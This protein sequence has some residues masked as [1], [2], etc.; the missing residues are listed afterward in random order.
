MSE[1][2]SADLQKQLQDSQPA[3]RTEYELEGLATF[4]FNYGFQEAYI[5]G[6]RS[7]FLTQSDYKA[8][9]GVETI[10]DFRTVLQDTDYIVAMQG[11]Q[12]P[13]PQTIYAK[14]YEKWVKEF[15]FLKMQGTGKVA[16][17]L[18]LLSHEYLISNVVAL[19][20]ATVKGSSP[21]DVLAHCHPLGNS[22][23]LQS[24]FT[25][26]KEDSLLDLYRIVL[27]DMPIGKYF[28]KYFDAE[29]RSGDPQRA[30][31]GT[32]KEV[33][34]VVISDQLRKLWL[35]ELWDYSQSLGGA[36]WEMMKPM[37]EFEADRRA[38][39]IV[40]NSI[41]IKSSYS[42]PQHRAARQDLFCSFGKLYPTC[43]ARDIGNFINVDSIAA[44]QSAVDYVPEYANALRQA[45]EGTTTLSDALKAIEVNTL[46]AGCAGQAHLG[47][48]Y[49]FSKLKAIE[50]ENIRSLANS[51]ALRRSNKA[52]G[53]F[54]P[55]F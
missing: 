52:P 54:V 27:V 35:E 24:L 18:D 13:R 4:A 53:K 15:E 12:N 40:Y 31:H 26:D 49:S 33:D 46:I 11:I 2:S 39:E 38:I 29:V 44:L 45:V 6:L 42:D 55:I 32:F 16:A 37:L 51:A 47:T 50:L 1:Q 10:E 17:F 30:L 41:Q 36:T 28:S 9:Q 21:E 5:K 34:M 23:Y 19:I 3:E 8:L 48:I 20:A 25:F 7:T 14:A 22:P 43:T